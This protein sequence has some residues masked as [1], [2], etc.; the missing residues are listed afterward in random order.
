MLDL[1]RLRLLRELAHRGTL[2]AVA[3]ALN[4]SPST[5]SEQLAQL[6]TEA[7]VPLLEH[8]GRRV[9]L[10]PQ[11]RILVAHTEQILEQLEQAP[12]SPVT[13]TWS[14]PRSIPVT[15]SRDRTASTPRTC[16]P[17]RSAWPTR[18]ACAPAA[19]RVRWR[20]WPGIRG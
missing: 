3:T 6:E 7:G 4:Y 11:G 10:T 13:S 15:G 17:T 16:S 14:S 1:R 20:P 2:H 12:C 9:R 5:V 8:V 19:T 18:S